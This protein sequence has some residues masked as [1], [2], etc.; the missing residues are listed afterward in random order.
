MR[1]KGTGQ[2]RKYRKFRLVD[3]IIRCDSVL[4]TLDTMYSEYSFAK[5]KY[6][7][8]YYIF[9]VTSGYVVG[10]GRSLNFAKDTSKEYLKG[11]HGKFGM[12]VEHFI[13]K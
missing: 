7:G 6:N 12:I 1:K 3:E 4:I 9:E 8:I 10:Q 11:T 13:L 5:S 2:R